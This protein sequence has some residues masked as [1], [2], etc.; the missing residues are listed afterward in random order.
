[1]DGDGVANLSFT[2]K[3]LVSRPVSTSHIRTPGCLDA[4]VSSSLPLVPVW[5]PLILIIWMLLNGADSG[6]IIKSDFTG[7]IKSWNPP[8]SSLCLILIKIYL[9]SRFQILLKI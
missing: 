3:Q 5:I 8:P 4:L 9:K 1:M 2:I 7:F 6:W